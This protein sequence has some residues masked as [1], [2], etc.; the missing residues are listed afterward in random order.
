MDG[1]ETIQTIPPTLPGFCAA[2]R[3]QALRRASS[4]RTGNSWDQAIRGPQQN[5]YIYRIP[6]QAGGFLGIF[7][8][9]HIKHMF[10]H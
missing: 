5:M 8:V 7:S 3:E 1:I 2:G 9:F 4:G 6:P 10:K